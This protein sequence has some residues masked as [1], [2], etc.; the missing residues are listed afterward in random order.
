MPTNPMDLRNRLNDMKKKQEEE[1]KAEKRKKK[2]I[3]TREAKKRNKKAAKEEK[4]RTEE[5]LEALEE[6]DDDLAYMKNTMGFSKF[7]T[8]KMRYNIW[9]DTTIPYVIIQCTYI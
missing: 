5:A 6:E 7:Q 8:T 1:R 3:R 9:N 4:K 2:N